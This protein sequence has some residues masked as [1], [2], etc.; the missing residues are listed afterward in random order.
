MA[1]GELLR[2]VS[3]VFFGFELQEKKPELRII[4]N[5]K[6]QWKRYL[7]A[8]FEDILQNYRSI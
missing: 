5:K 1:E 2:V 6:A 7:I 4:N 8:V 3:V